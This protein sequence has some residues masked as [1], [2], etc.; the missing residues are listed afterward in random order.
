MDTDATTMQLR[1]PFINLPLIAENELLK[2]G[3]LSRSI[4]ISNEYHKKG[5]MASFPL[6]IFD[7][8]ATYPDRGTM[9]IR[10]QDDQV[11]IHNPH[12]VTMTNTRAFADGMVPIIYNK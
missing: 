11:Y 6:Y 8:N 12:I 10:V 4:G 5:G 3:T 1:L 7:Y 9:Y 2:I